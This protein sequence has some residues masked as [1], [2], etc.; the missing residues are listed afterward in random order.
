ML[1]SLRLKRVAVVTE[2][3]AEQKWASIRIVKSIVV[4][5]HW[6]IKDLFRAADK[7]VNGTSLGC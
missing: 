2:D 3:S 1:A 7:T 5:W 6:L 4:G